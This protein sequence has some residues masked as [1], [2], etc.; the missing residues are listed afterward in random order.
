MLHSYSS[1][2]NSAVKATLNDGKHANE[3]KFVRPWIRLPYSGMTENE[4]FNE[5]GISLIV[6]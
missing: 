5:H 6:V 3:V 1:H 2:K 4:W